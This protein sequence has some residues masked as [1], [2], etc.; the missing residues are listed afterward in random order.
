M[1]STKEHFDDHPA[2]GCSSCDSVDHPGDVSHSQQKTQHL[3]IV[4]GLLASFLL[5]EWTAGLWSHSLSL[6]ADAGHLLSD[7]TALGIT[8][9]ANWLAQQPATGQAT[10]GHRRVESLAALVNSLS[11]CGL[12]AFISWEA[13]HRFPV[14]EPVMGLPMLIVAGVGLVVNLLNIK[15]LHQHSH[16]DL[17]LRGALL[18]V[19]ADT[20]SSVGIMLAALAVHFLHWLW[21]DAAVSLLVAG[22]IVLSALPLIQESLKILMEYAPRHL[23]PMKVKMTLKSF[24][25]VRQVERLNI[26]AIT[27]GQVILCAQLTVDSLNA[28]ERDQLLWQL[29]TQL[30][31]EYG[32]YESTLQLSNQKSIA[33]VR[34]HPLFSQNLISMFAETPRDSEAV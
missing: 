6:Q 32:I 29:Q 1:L 24:S 23:D 3:W 34:L 7:V 14:P 27:P 8:L 18:H 20:A 31:R 26:W 33:S 28:E 19:F 15:L 4:L 10:F 17:N 12:A 5:V 11:L 16:D 2:V 9:I 25:A 13:I 22:L 30:R 21:V